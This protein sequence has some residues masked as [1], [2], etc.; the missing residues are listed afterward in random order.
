MI[1]YS[2]ESNNFMEN[3][4]KRLIIVGNGFD[5]HHNMKTKYTDYRKYLLYNGK[6]DIVTCFEKYNDI[7]NPKFMWNHL[8]E[9]IGMLPYE[10]AYSYLIG[11]ESEEWHD[12]VN[13][14]FQ[15]EIDKMRLYWPGMKDNLMD[16]IK[17]IEYTNK[18]VHLENLINQSTSF[19]SF[20]YTN[21]LEVLY[22]VSKSKITYIHGDASITNEL[23][24][25]HNL[26]SWYPEWDPSNPNEDIRLLEASEIMDDHYEKT[27]KQIDSIIAKHQD[28]FAKIYMY[29][30]IYVLGL[31]YN[32]TDFRYLQEI[33]IN[34]HNAKWYFNWY[35]QDDFAAIDDYAHKLGISNYEKINIDY[36]N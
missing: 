17:K 35:S 1:Q 36:F 12:S 25:G 24:L 15:Y 30:E 33:M 10:E 2:K 3:S 21:T 22:N 20:N 4:V 19:L 34:N 7:D 13:H 23:I 16:W 6:S 18:D 9:I 11:Y 26:K 8:E 27:K 5:L 32:D 28:F 14:D 29:D 31:S